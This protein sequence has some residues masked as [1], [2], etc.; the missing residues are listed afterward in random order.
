MGKRNKFKAYLPFAVNVFQR[1]LSYKA[2]VIIFIFGDIIMLAVTYYLWKGVYGSSPE[3][4]IKGFS[5]DEMII[6][7]LVSFI[8]MLMTSVNIIYDISR[9]V[10]DGSIAINLVR[11]VS[12]EKRMLFQS[13]GNIFYNFVTI[14]LI[15]FTLVNI[16]FY[17][18]KGTLSLLNILLY[19][20]STMLGALINFYFSYSF[21]LLSFK[22]TNMWGL[23]QIMNA[24]VN[25]IS[26]ALIPITF[27]PS[28]FQNI[29]NLFPFSSL[30]YT[31]TM[32]YL[33]K[34]TGIELV[35]A[36][37]LQIIWIIILAALAKFMWGTLVK[38][39]TILGG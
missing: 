7:V 18:Y 30:I 12:Y 26:G 13:L 2:N 27:F 4:I 3:S 17:H 34:L 36:L 35:K 31:P 15:S 28:I 16:L 19:I 6:Y 38:K 1:Q 10:K 9:E 20:I 24:I 29:I 33:G 37:S 25:L 21:G 39:L 8:T 22:I 32:I 14:F 11:P 23:S 5:L